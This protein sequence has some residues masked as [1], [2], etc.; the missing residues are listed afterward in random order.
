M[1]PKCSKRSQL[2]VKPSSV[3]N[4]KWL[5]LWAFPWPFF[6]RWLAS[7][8]L[9]STPLR[10]S[11][12]MTQVTTVCLK[13]LSMS[14]FTEST[15]WPQQPLFSCST[16]SEER[17]LWLYSFL[18]RLSC[19][20]Y[21]VYSKDSSNVTTRSQSYSACYLWLSLSSRVV[22]SP[23]C[24]WQKF[25]MILQPHKPLLPINLSTWSCLYCHHL[26]VMPTQ[27]KESLSSS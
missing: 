11:E 20:C 3:L 14:S 9:C 8:L 5:P 25:A 4:T 27:N 18:A 13:S 10:S 16:T 1:A 24:I 23:G 7:M 6:S 12:L 21:L 2:A 15:S 26:S 17:V 19:S 22:L